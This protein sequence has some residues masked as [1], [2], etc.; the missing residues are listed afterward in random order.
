M[1]PAERNAFRELNKSN[2]LRFPLKETVSTQAHKVALLIQAR[3]GDIDIPFGKGYSKMTCIRETNIAL[4]HASRLVRCVVE[5]K[6]HASD[7]VTTITASELAR[8]IRAGIWEYSPHQL[9]Q[10]PQVGPIMTRKLIGSDIKTVHELMSLSSADVERILSRNPPFGTQI[11]DAAS[12]FPKL[13]LRAAVVEEIVKR[14]ENP[15]L[16]IQAKLA[17]ENEKIPRSKTG[18]PSV[19]FMATTF[20]GRVAYTWSGSLT[21]VAKDKVLVV[22]FSV[23]MLC[24]SDYV[25]CHFFCDSIVGTTKTTD[26]RPDF[27]PSAFVLTI[28]KQQL[29]TFKKPVAESDWEKDMEDEF[30][31]EDMLSAMELIE[32]HANR[33]QTPQILQHQNS[34]SADDFVD[35]DEVESEIDSTTFTHTHRAKTEADLAQPIQMA[36]GKWECNHDCRNG[37]LIKGNKVCRH[38]CCKEGLDRPIKPKKR[39]VK[40]NYRTLL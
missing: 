16:Q 39:K 37:K 24:E 31:D 12:S 9:R 34:S 29:P 4:E 17:F 14:G 22:S 2:M 1:K 10:L 23:E 5:C 6:A 18:I 8:S 32:P 35:I 38:R 19:S 27:P 40:V 30:A 13:S 20:S 36:N 25:S 3:L 21:S 26:I 7:A 33:S 15:K 11:L 28:P